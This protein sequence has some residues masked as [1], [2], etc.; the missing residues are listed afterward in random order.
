MGVARALALALV[1][2]LVP[3]AGPGAQPGG[4]VGPAL[5]E[6][7]RVQREAKGSE[8]RTDALADETEVLLEEYLT[9]NREHDALRDYN[10]QVERLVRGQEAELDALAR[11]FADIELTRQGIL[12]L[13]ARMVQ[14]L[15]EFVTLDLPFLEDERSARVANLDTLLGR[16]DVSLP[17]K[18]R[19]IMEAY[20]VE[21]EYGRTIEAYRAPLPAPGDGRTVELLRIGRTA[22]YYL[23]LDG[24][25]A[26]RFDPGQRGW[27]VL[28]A[29]D[30]ETVARG[31][32]VA[33]KELPP[34]LLQL[35][36]AAPVR[37][38]AP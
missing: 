17:E 1:L 20:Q 11:Q 25:E 29:R 32:R 12:P 10:D 23:S 19:R 24:R 35:P 36:V 6:R 14:V 5:E 28:E 26:G 13:L 7:V 30:R 8:A 37:V 3:V 4:T 9:L 34:E 16:A 18:Y 2:G 21:V 38:K 27:V 31:L 15:S 33:R 22:L